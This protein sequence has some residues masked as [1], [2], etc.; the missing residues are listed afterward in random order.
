MRQSLSHRGPDF[1]AHNDRILLSDEQTAIA[2]ERKADTLRARGRETYSGEEV[3]H[4]YT[5]E[6]VLGGVGVTN[7]IE[8][9]VDSGCTN[10]MTGNRNAFV[11]ETY[12]SL[13]A[14]RPQMQTAT[15]ELVSAAG[16]GTVQ[17]YTWTP[18]GGHQRLFLTEVLHVPRAPEA[19]L[20]SV[21]QLTKKGV[22][23]AFTDD[24]A[25]SYQDGI[26]IAITEKWNKLYKLI[27][28]GKYLD[29]GLLPSKKDNTATAFSHHR[30]GHL[31]LPAVLKMS[32]TEV[33]TG[34]P[35]LQAN[36]G[37]NRCTAC[38][39]GKITAI[40]FRASTHRTKAPLELVH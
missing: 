37:A 11:K 19:G 17:T 16:I 20:I 8:W 35:C 33:A 22:K 14:N 28:S 26:L 40:L 9:V 15:G 27:Q 23:I 34:M 39:T 2:T 21:S 31:H 18:G 32:N 24:A 6:R 7:E 1:G 36:N 3:D 10:H 38:L 25:E 30:L 4:G 5:V 29:F 12:V 13:S